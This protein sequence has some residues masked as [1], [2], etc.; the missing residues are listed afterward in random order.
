MKNRN[1]GRIIWGL[2]LVIVGVIFT[3]NVLGLIEVDIFFAGWWTLFIIVPSFI[4]L[5]TSRGKTGNLI[6]LV[7]G[8]ALLLAAQ[9]IIDFDLAWRLLIPVIIILIGLKLIFTSP[10]N[11]RTSAKIKELKND[12]KEP[13]KDTAAFSSREINYDGQIFEGAALD[14]V[15]GSITCDL[16]NALIE[17]DCVI[18]AS[19]VF[20]G[21]DIKVPDNIRVKIDSNALFGGVSDKRKK[22]V[23]QETQP[24]NGLTLY[25]EANCVFGGV[26][27]I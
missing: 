15:F 17:K 19:A 12:S 11:R 13:G 23:R 14:A 2:V 18:T 1:V 8:V 21:I 27:I 20:A 26:D 22:T 5:F 25:I 6:A 10:S 7:I 3:L 16:R 9:D 24:N 4:G